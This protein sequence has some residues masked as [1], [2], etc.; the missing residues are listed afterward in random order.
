VESTRFRL[1]RLATQVQLLSSNDEFPR[2]LKR[3]EKRNDRR[4]EKCM[5]LHWQCWRRPWPVECPE[6]KR[7][8]TKLWGAYRLRTPAGDAVQLV[9]SHAPKA[10]VALCGAVV[11]AFAE[12]ARPS[13]SPTSIFAP[14]S[15]PAQS[16]FDL[17]LFVLMVTGAVFIV[18]FSLLAYAVVKFRKRRANEGREPAQ[19]LRKQSTGTG[20][21]RHSDSHCFGPVPGGSACN[22]EGSVANFGAGVLI[23]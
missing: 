17:S 22:R 2:G 8:R 6:R 18:V 7:K 13:L 23:G 12:P 14:V 4:N 10:L 9:N 16:I 1:Y 15:T 5:D 21:D 3:D 11:T 19:V 20:V